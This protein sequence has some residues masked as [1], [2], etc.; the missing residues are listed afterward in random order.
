MKAQLESTHQEVQHWK[1]AVAR[2]A[3]K[4]KDQKEIW[5]E[6]LRIV[7]IEKK[8]VQ[9]ELKNCIKSAS[10]RESQLT[11]ELS[12]LKQSNKKLMIFGEQREKL[13]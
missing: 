5:E 13:L 3:D 4:L 1:D 2:V 6:K 8:N 10:E 9:E 11:K 12:I 7:N